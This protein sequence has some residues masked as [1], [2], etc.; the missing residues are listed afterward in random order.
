MKKNY[1]LLIAAMSLTLLPSA[2]FGQ[3]AE[4][5]INRYN[6]LSGL[7][8]YED[9]TGHSLYMDMDMLAMGGV[10]MNMKGIILYPLKMRF[11]VSAMGQ[12]MLMVLNGDK[13]WMVADG[14]KMALPS[15]QIKQMT[16]Q[17]DVFSNMKYDRERFEFTLLDPVT[18]NGKKYD[19][20]KALEK[21]KTEPDD[22]YTLYF[23]NKTGF[24][25]RATIKVSSQVAP[26]DVEI[27]FGDVKDFKG[28]KIPENM[29][30]KSNNII[31]AEIKINNLE[32][33][34]PTEE[35]MFAEPE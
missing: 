14:N 16:A 2:V 9:M 6:R 30:I 35:W 25:S 21:T 17:F 7:D 32:I 27:S 28:I 1:L 5:I 12:D 19:V 33:D 34:Y 11:D 24:L 26:M 15:E 29:V 13:G 4:E 3:T 10:D 18:E 31:A 8:T 20:V 23:D 22:A